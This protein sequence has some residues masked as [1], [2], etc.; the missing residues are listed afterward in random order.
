MA[1]VE[2]VIKKARREL[3]MR[4]ILPLGQTIPF[5]AIGTLDDN[6]A[7]R[8]WG[9]SKSLLGMPAGR[10]LTDSRARPDF[11]A[12]SGRDVSLGFKA[13]GEASTLFPNL[14]KAKARVEVSFARKNSCLISARTL[15]VKTLS[16]PHKLADEIKR[17]YLDGAW[18]DDYV[19]VYQ[20]GWAGEYLGISADA[21]ETNVALSAKAAFKQQPLTAD[22]AG[23]F[24][25]SAHSKAITRHDARNALAFFNAYRVH[26]RWLVFW[27]KSVTV[28]PA[29]MRPDKPND[30]LFE[31][32]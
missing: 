10:P 29:A 16:E 28:R 11:G 6:G 25:V 7:F 26:R 18:D 19:V 30:P 21:D 13:A 12:T 31:D 24:T 17:R 14:P 4:P 22:I 5:G 8:Y 23:K 15:T 32:A 27:K 2:E 1:G 20:L 3:G 9:S